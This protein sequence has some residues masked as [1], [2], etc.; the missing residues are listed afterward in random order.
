MKHL[1]SRRRQFAT[2]GARSV[3][4]SILALVSLLCV[5]L[6]NGAGLAA[7]N[8][9]TVT[10]PWIRVVVPSRPAAGYF[11][12]SNETTNARALVGVESRS[13]G[14]LMMHQ[15]LH[16]NGQDRMVAVKSI[17]IAP[18]GVVKFAPGGYHLMCMSPSKD[19]TPGPSVPVTL[20]FADGGAVTVRFRVRGAMDK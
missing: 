18:H 6:A 2:L 1:L 17:P 15:S 12:L 16:E 14:M 20:H 8:G 10:D 13:C 4:D 5:L 19:V 7:E 9:L 11:T 3:Y